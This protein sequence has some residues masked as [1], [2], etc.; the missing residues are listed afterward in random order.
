MNPGM[1]KLLEAG[2]SEVDAAKRKQDYLEFQRLAMTDLPV[3]PL[4]AVDSVTVAN[5]KVHNH[6][7]DAH[8]T[9]GNFA[10]VYLS[11]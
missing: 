5:K 7:I 10:D 9:F 4:V 6:S 8:G 11:K 1:D 3:L 2:A